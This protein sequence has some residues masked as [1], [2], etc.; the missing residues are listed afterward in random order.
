[1]DFRIGDAYVRD[2]RLPATETAEAGDGVATK[3]S[4]GAAPPPDTRPMS[5]QVWDV[6]EE[7]K[8]PGRIASLMQG[9]RLIDQV[10]TPTG[11]IDEAEWDVVATAMRS[12]LLAG[13]AAADADSIYDAFMV[14]AAVVEAQRDQPPMVPVEDAPAPKKRSPRKR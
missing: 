2:W 1:M 6:L 5:D 10:M 8:T 12:C 13:I 7:L 11:D 9:I 4:E 14:Q 3:P